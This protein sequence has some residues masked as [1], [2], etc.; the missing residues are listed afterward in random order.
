LG[1]GTQKVLR[2]RSAKLCGEFII[3]DVVRH[4]QAQFGLQTQIRSVLHDASPNRGVS[5]IST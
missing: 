2:G 5:C 3:A 4:S 1:F